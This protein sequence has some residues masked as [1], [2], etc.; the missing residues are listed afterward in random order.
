MK[1]LYTK[2]PAPQGTGAKVY[3]PSGWCGVRVGGLADDLLVVG[4]I[5]VD[6]LVQERVE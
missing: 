2:A 3:Q 5:G 1:S 4:I 6:E